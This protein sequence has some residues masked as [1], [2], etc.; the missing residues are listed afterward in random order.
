MEFRV[1]SQPAADRSGT[2]IL[3][4]FSHPTEPSHSGGSIGEYVHPRRKFRQDLFYHPTEIEIPTEPS[5]LF[6]HSAPPNSQTPAAKWAAAAA[7]LLPSP[8][9]HLPHLRRNC[10]RSTPQR[11][12]PTSPSGRRPQQID[13]LVVPIFSLRTCSAP[14]RLFPGA[15]RRKGGARG[16]APSCRSARPGACDLHACG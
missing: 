15:P 14:A 8:V 7:P 2:K 12:V 4:R 10:S 9:P 6:L 13:A 5:P 1:A 16:S 3:P 11:P